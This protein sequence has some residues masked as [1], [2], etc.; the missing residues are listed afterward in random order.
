MEEEC[1]E[2]RRRRELKNRKRDHWIGKWKKKEKSN[3]N[4]QQEKKEG[5]VK[6]YWGNH[7]NGVIWI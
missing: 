1:G 2:K 4:Q 5:N 6:E 7:L 3:E